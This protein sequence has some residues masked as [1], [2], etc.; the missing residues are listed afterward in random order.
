MTTQVNQQVV[1]PAPSETYTTAVRIRDFA[2]MNPQEFHRSK[3][4]EDPQE[5][6]NDIHKVTDIIGVTLVE[7]ADLAAY[8]L[9]GVAYTWRSDEPLGD[10]PSTLGDPQARPSSF[11][12]PLNQDQKG[13]FMACNG[14][15]YKASSCSMSLGDIVLLRGSIQWNADCF[16]HRLFDPAPSGLRVL[17][18]SA[19][20]VPSVNCQMCLAML[21][22]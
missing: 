7:S 3:L 21:R 9:K 20:C 13:L 10:T 4:E 22:L 2:R 16:F 6:L 11:L 17:E 1:A 5:F 8:Q 14:A 15:K 19:E 18:Q 12:Q